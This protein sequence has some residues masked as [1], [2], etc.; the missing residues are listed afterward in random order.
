MKVTRV[1][2]GQSTWFAKKTF[3]NN[4][5]LRCRLSSERGKTQR[6]SRIPTSEKNP[7]HFIIQSSYIQ[8]NIVHRDD[9]KDHRKRS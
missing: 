3:I 2:L 1:K 6:A 8:K 9:R 4:F 5:R 7:K